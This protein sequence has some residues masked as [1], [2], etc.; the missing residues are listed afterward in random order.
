MGIL[1]VSIAVYFTG[2]KMGYSSNGVRTLTFV[3]LIVSNI[4]VI[5]SNRSWTTNIF[6]I[7]I[8]PN[9]AVKWVIGGAVFFL[10]LIM[11]VPFL[12]TLFQFEKITILELT[13][14]TTAGLSSVIWF[15][16]YKQIKSSKK[17]IST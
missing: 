12:L 1:L 16:I 8:T 13:V 2:I 10:F 14:C 4:A 3:T 17:V 5:L 9:K 11:E 15:E 6:K 7:M